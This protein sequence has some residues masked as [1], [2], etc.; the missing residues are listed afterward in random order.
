MHWLA[1][2]QFFDAVDEF[3]TR[4]RAGMAGYIND[5]QSHSPFKVQEPSQS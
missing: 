2:P 4:E 3:L 5:L 1:H